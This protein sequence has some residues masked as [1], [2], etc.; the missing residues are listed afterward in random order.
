MRGR[1]E[2]RMRIIPTGASRF[3]SAVDGT[4]NPTTSIAAPT[5]AR[6]ISRA[7]PFS[8]ICSEDGVLSDVLFL[9]LLVFPPLVDFFFGRDRLI[10]EAE[11]SLS[12]FGRYAPPSEGLGNSYSPGF[13][14]K[15]ESGFW[16]SSVRSRSSLVMPQ[17]RTSS[18]LNRSATAAHRYKVL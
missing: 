9:E 17:V 3:V 10:S 18:S 13:L 11:Q 14:G 15:T 1:T 8:E 7:K 2:V 5:P 6:R 4:S 12:F 16:A